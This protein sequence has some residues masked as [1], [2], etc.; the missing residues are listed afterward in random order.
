MKGSI[1]MKNYQHWSMETLNKKR[2]SLLEEI[3]KHEETL[4]V[5][6]S[7]LYQIFLTHCI[8]TA[9]EEVRAIDAELC[10]REHKGS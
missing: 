3:S 1:D 5:T 9:K 2:D 4:S 8:K 7:M 6:K 10:Y